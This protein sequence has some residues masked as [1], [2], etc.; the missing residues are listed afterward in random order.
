MKKFLFLLMLPVFGYAALQNSQS[1]PD[2]KKTYVVI[3]TKYGE[4]KAILYDETPLHRDNFIKNVNAGV[5]D[6]LLFHRVI[7]DF[8]IQGGDPDSKKAKPGD[9]L[10]NGGLNYTIPAEFNTKY[11]HKKGALAAARQGD[12]VNPKKESSS[13]QFYI[14]QGQVFTDQSIKKIEARIDQMTQQSIFF[15][16][17]NLA[18]NA[19]K[20]KEFEAA[21]AAKDQQK[22]MDIYNGFKDQIQTI[23]KERGGNY[24]LPADK[25]E[26]YKTI[27]G[28]PHL[29]GSYTVFGEVVSGLNIIDSIAKVKTDGNNRPL[30]DVRYSIKIVVE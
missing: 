3:T 16:L 11:F 17:L 6:S 29:D 5:Y 1:E 22:T 8:M 28:A 13:T 24:I 27:G 21:Y 23:F 15:E 9:L 2:E 19:D 14:V 30:T 7:K 4:I 12:D 18:A 20:K 26:A 25:K 10:G